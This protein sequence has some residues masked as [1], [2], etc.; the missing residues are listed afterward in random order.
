MKTDN[1]MGWA[2]L[3]LHP[4]STT[5]AEGP[6]RGSHSHFSQQLPLTEL[7][8]FLFCQLLGLAGLD[9]LQPPLYFILYA[10]NLPQDK[11]MRAGAC[12]AGPLPPACLAMSP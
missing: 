4:H 5:Q 1:S 12:P 9:Q 2:A 7:I 8:P 3:S 10:V 6:G 11:G